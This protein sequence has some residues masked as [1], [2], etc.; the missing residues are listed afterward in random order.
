VHRPLH[1]GT[2]I[3]DPRLGVQDDSVRGR[4]LKLVRILNDD[5]PTIWFL[6]RNLRQ[7]CVYQSAFSGASG[8]DYQDVSVR[9]NGGLYCANLGT[10]S[11]MSTLTRHKP[12]RQRL[13]HWFL[14]AFSD[15]RL[16]KT[17]RGTHPRAY[18]SLSHQ[19]AT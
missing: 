1:R 19:A 6:R 11:H 4:T 5:Q 16:L 10:G 2:Q 15:I 9:S 14:N 17:R 7:R 18:R 12:A 13:T 3:R 8:A